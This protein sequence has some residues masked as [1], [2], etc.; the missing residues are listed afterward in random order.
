MERYIFSKTKLAIESKLRL[1]KQRQLELGDILRSMDRDGDSMDDV[2]MLQAHEEIKGLAVKEYQLR[3][4][5][6]SETISRESLEGKK[7]VGL[8]HEVECRVLFPN[9]ERENLLFTLGTTV[10]A[11]YLNSKREI[12]VSD[13]SPIGK[14][15]LG[16]RI[17]DVRQIEIHGEMYVVE[18][19]GFRPSSIF[20]EDSR[21]SNSPSNTGTDQEGI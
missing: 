15:V 16:A 11:T 10:D 8:G 7:E 20:S 14:A 3:K 17:G 18:I 9:T 6:G 2:V 4:I 13:E 21:L 1:V 12:I 5:L 19:L